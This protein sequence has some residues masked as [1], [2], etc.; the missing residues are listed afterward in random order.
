[1]GNQRGNEGNL[2]GNVE[3]PGNQSCGAGNQGGN[4]EIAAEIT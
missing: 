1:M 2:G 4:L 3:N